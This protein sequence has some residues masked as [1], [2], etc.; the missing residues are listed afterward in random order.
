LMIRVD[1]GVCLPSRVSFAR[2][3]HTVCLGLGQ[4]RWRML[5][6]APRGFAT[7]M[8]DSNESHGPCV[9]ELP[10]PSILV[11]SRPIIRRRVGNQRA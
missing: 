2:A 6:T 1:S 3:S 9:P 7:V 11:V 5:G 10:T 8:D 4:A